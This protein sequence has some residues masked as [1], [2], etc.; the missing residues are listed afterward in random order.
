MSRRK[1]KH[2]EDILEQGKALIKF[3]MENPC[4]AAY[5][6]LGVDLAPIQRVV[7]QDMWF[8][9]Y[10]IVVAGR[11]YGKSYLLGL[12]AA[13]SSMLKPGYRTGL[14]SPSF[15]QCLVLS[16]D[17][18]TFWT[19][20]GLI[21]SSSVFYDSINC[22][23]T[24]TQSL[25][26]NNRILNKWVNE[27]KPCI[28]ITTDK[29]YELSGTTDHRILTLDKDLNLI[30][31]ELK[32][33]Q[34]GELVTIKK[35]FNY[36]G[37]N[38]IIETQDIED[39]LSR[40]MGSITLPKTLNKDLSYLLGLICGDGF[41]EGDNT[42]RN[43]W[44]V[45]F[46][47]G[48]KDLIDTYVSILKE[49]FNI[50]SKIKMNGTTY[51]VEISSIVL[52]HYIKSLG[53]SNC[54][55]KDKIIPQIIKK[56][57]K[58]NILSFISGLM[59]TDG[60]CNVYTYAQSRSCE[61]NLVSTSKQLCREVQSVLLNVGIESS[62]AIKDKEKLVYFNTTEKNHLCNEC[63]RLRIHGRDNLVKFYSTIGFRL[64]RKNEILSEYTI[65]FKKENYNVIVQ[66]TF[67][68]VY[69]LAILCK[70]IKNSNKEFLKFYINKSK[71]NKKT[72]FTYNKIKDL[73]LYAESISIDGL[74]YNKLKN[75]IDLNLCFLKV[76]KKEEFLSETIDIEV[77]NESCYW[78]NGFINHNS[79]MVFAEVEKLYTQSS[80]FR[81]ACEKPPTRG[82]DSC[83]LK[84]KSVSGVSPSFIE[85]VPLGNDGAKIR[86]S[87]FY[88]I[89][90][91]ELAQVPDSILDKV[92][93]PMGATSLAPMERVRRIEQQE[94]LIKLGLAEQS[95]FERETVNKMIMTSSGYYKFNHMW[96]RMKDH[97]RQIDDAA[98]NKVESPY[99]VW[100]I[101]YWDLPSGFL[102][103]DNIN[104]AKRVMSSSEF[105]MEYEAAMISDSEGFF[106]ASLL[107]QCTLSSGFFIEPRGDKNGQYVMGVDPNQGGS[108]SAGIVIIRT[109]AVNRVVNVLELKKQTTQETTETIQ[110]ICNNY[111]I[112][113]IFMDK[114]GGGKAICDLLEAGHNNYDNIIDRTNEEHKHLPGRHILEMVTFN[115]AWISD[116]NFT[117]KSMLENRNLLFPEVSVSTTVDLESKLYDSITTLK[118]QMLNIVVT[119]TPSGS[120]HF[121]TPTKSQN[122]DL[123]SALILA[124]HG[125]RSIEKELE[126]EQESILHNS[127]GM[128]RLRNSSQ[129]Y[130]REVQ[131]MGG[132]NIAT[133]AAVLKKKIK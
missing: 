112:N 59:D 116:A 117:T 80:I 113:R 58:D 43:L 81:E 90:V 103:M 36:F 101:P 91:D 14:L 78:A 50:S 10:V 22:G 1:N 129:N 24:K 65:N 3:Y 108:A 87:R 97:W 68:S 121:D 20:S 124:A 74:E 47:S 131:P 54:K 96:R 72:D 31:K 40:Y 46:C 55:A 77:E 71:K 52:W 37:N 126:G 94:K 34:D 105:R 128:I 4:I 86:G 102:D 26:S 83:Y 114:G 8:K 66:N 111:N 53:I 109:G 120:L 88:L 130:F 29:G 45:G 11:G 95:D 82:T 33:I 115:P 98:V 17:Y 61:I 64:D 84:F 67:D 99:A 119:Q 106:K 60:S 38:N 23:I 44:V 63:Y 127:S 51:V 39:K 6:L 30:Y 70:N 5:D 85:A 27:E 107:E 73:I 48:D 110:D 9:D 89:V 125:A 92:I 79:K 16:N 122:K 49:E 62:F 132:R 118:S 56:A 133:S 15:R 75:I 18:D 76:S 2:Y 25:I 7:F 42:K 93:R 123:Y 19:D 57:S 35:G 12:L 104:E 32:D 28:K 21:T 69:K 13:L 100:Q 41:I